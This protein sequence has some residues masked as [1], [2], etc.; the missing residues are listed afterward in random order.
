M[1]VVEEDGGVW[2]GRSEWRVVDVVKSVGGDETVVVRHSCERSLG[3]GN[4]YGRK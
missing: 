1:C 3:C 4:C 2:G